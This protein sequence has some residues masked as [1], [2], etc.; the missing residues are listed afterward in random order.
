MDKAIE[1]SDTIGPEHLEV[2]TANS[3]TDGRKCSSY[4]ALF[5][6]K[7]SAEVLGDYGA[8]PNHVL[9]T[10]GTAKYTGGL[11]VFTF[12]RIRDLGGGGAGHLHFFSNLLLH[13]YVFAP[14][15]LPAGSPVSLPRPHLSALLLGFIL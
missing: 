15:A 9:P 12:L 11:S 6:G 1:L 5:V 13:Y 8:G 14:S 7:L 3:E 4:G 2:Q 10:S